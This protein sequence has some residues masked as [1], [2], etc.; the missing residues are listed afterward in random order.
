[1]NVTVLSGQSV[2]DLAVQTSGDATSAISLAIANDMPITETLQPATVLT[3][4]AVANRDI[5]N[6]YTNKN[7]QPATAL[8]EFDCL[9]WGIFDKTFDDIFK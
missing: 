2:L 1:M 8:S 4:V 9:L 3:T 5:A 6:Y 7:L